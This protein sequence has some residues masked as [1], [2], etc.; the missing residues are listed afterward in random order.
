MQPHH[1]QQKT[2]EWSRLRALHFT[3]S[4]IGAF[5]VEPV[6]V[7]L[8]VKE[9]CAELEIL[10]IPHKKTEK[11]ETLLALLP[12]P[13]AYAKLLPAARN[14]ILGRIQ[15]A[16]IQ[17]IRDRHPEDRTEWDTQQL[18]WAEEKEAAEEKKL[19]YNLDIRRGNLLEPLAR[20][21]YEERM[22][23]KV[24][25]IGFVSHDFGGFGCSPDGL[26]S[27]A[28]N[29]D[30]THGLEIK[31]PSNEVHNG[32]LLDGVLPSDYELQVHM[33]MAVTGLPRWDFLSFC[34][35][36]A[37]FLISVE[38]TEFTDRLE[39]GLK[40]LVL[41]KAKIENE[42]AARWAAEYEGGAK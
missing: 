15:A 27:F 9:I 22:A 28:A 7:A 42:L 16:K 5:A 13:G 2:Q 40:T 6:A 33:S 36:E 41:E 14:A 37:Q 24:H 20:A 23:A 4:T 12:D 1:V 29:G 30:F 34:P 32:Y 8:T 18:E 31:C 21:Y 35:G 39:E 10:G 19:S 38:R 17:A 11:K 25:E 26:I 3:A